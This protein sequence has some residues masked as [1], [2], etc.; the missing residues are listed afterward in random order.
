MFN[1][2]HEAEFVERYLRGTLT[3]PTTTRHVPSV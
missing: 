1:P 3:E 2:Y